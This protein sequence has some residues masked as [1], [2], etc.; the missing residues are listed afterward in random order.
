MAIAL[1]RWTRFPAGDG[2][3]ARWD[4]HLDAI[5]MLR[6]R[7]VGG[8]TIIG[9]ISR[10]LANRIVN[11][12]QQRRYLRRIVRILIRQRLRHNHAAGGINRQM[13]LSPFPARLRTMLRLQPLTRSV[14]WQ[15]GVAVKTW[16][17]TSAPE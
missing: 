13:Q 7:L 9:T 10:H 12:I 6:D 8:R 4:H 17:G 2:R 3:R 1:G 14:T 16:T 11:L 15:P 5:A